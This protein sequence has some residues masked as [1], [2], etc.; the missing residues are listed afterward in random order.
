MN[1]CDIRRWYFGSLCHESNFES[2][3]NYFSAVF[4]KSRC[5]FKTYLF[6]HTCLLQWQI[7]DLRLL[8]VY[9]QPDVSIG[10]LSCMRKSGMLLQNHPSLVEPWRPNRMMEHIA[11]DFEIHPR[12][13]LGL[14]LFTVYTNKVFRDKR[15]PWRHCE[16][17]GRFKN[18]MLK[19]WSSKTMRKNE[20]TDAIR[21][22]RKIE[23]TN[24]LIY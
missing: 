11:S 16:I 22:V 10:M 9:Q 23:T 2:N 21:T 19:D 1:N 24:A 7:Y 12:D 6:Q 4:R 18:Q 15:S 5:N 3:L 17:R 13:S 14:S 20:T 8:L